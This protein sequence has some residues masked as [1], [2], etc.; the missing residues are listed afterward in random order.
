MSQGWSQEWRGRGQ[1]WR[2]R[3]QELLFAFVLHTFTKITLTHQR[4]FDLTIETSDW[5]FFFQIYGLISFF[6]EW[7]RLQEEGEKSE[8]VENKNR[9][10]TRPNHQ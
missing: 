4:L 10:P 6:P 7:A 5:S 9:Q 3:G 8:K 1:E 2:G